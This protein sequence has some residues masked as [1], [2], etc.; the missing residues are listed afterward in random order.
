VIVVIVFMAGLRHRGFDGHLLLSGP[1]IVLFELGLWLSGRAERGTS[2][3]RGSD[4]PDGRAATGG[5]GGPG[6]PAGVTRKVG[7]GVRLLTRR[8]AGP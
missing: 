6:E 7:G 1:M 5:A 2:T 3:E 8:G 4:E